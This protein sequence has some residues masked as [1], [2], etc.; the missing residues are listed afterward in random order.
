MELPLVLPELPRLR[1]RREPDLL[2]LLRRRP[3][4][5]LPLVL[6]LPEVLP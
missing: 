6:M 5:L 3:L 2:S 1:L 4:V